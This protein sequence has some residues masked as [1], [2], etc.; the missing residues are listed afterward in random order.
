MS[1]IYT[2][3]GYINTRCIVRLEA[4]VKRH[5]EW[6][7]RVTFAQGQ[8]LRTTYALT[9]AEEVAEEAAQ[10]VPATPGFV[11]IEIGQEP[12]H[13]VIRT[14]VVAWRICEDQAEPVCPEALSSWTPYKTRF[15]RAVLTPES[16]LIAACGTRYS[17]I[18]EFRTRAIEICELR[19][20][21]AA[22]SA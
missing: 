2:E 5:N 1:F 4:G 10:V 6:R 16:L 22:E 7:A 14:P 20:K 18:E 15:L 12:P 19:E 21:Q 9:P 3:D 13:E 11:R 17:S 8:E